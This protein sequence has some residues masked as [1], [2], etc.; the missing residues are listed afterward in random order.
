M[1]NIW[2]KI[3]AIIILSILGLFYIIPWQS[4]GL[5]NP[6]NLNSS[7]YKLGLDL[8][9][10]IELDYKINLEERKKEKWYDKNK[11]KN[12]I[13]QLKL[14]VDKRISSLWIDDSVIT[15]A[16]YSWEQ[17]II[18]QIPLKWKNLKEDKKNIER[19]KAAVWKVVKIMFKEPRTSKL[20]PQDWEER[21]NL[22]KQLLEKQKNSKYNFF[23]IADQYRD[24]YD[25]VYDWNKVLDKDIFNKIFKDVEL[26]K[27]LVPKIVETNSWAILTQINTNLIEDWYFV[28]NIED[29]K[30]DKVNFDYAYIAK[31]PSDWIPAKDSKWRVLDDKYFVKSWVSKNQA[32]LPQ[33]ELIFNTEWWKIFGEITK[34]AAKRAEPNNLIAIF[35][36]W[37]LLT[38]PSVHEA[39]YGGRA[40]ITWNY[41]PQEAEQL[42]NNINTW[43]IP[44]PIYLT[45]ERSID[46]KLGWN[47]LEK[48]IK[49]WVA[50]LILIFIF[51]IIVYRLSWVMA[52]IALVVYTILVL[53]VIKF[54][55]N[56]LT[57]AS[58]AWLIL[59]IWIA[60]DANVLIFE[61]IKDELRDHPNQ[62][63]I[64]SIQ[65]WFNNSWSAIWD[66]NITWLIIS[67]ILYIFWVNM[68]KWFGLM[69]GIWIVVSLLTAMWVSRIFTLALWKSKI[70]NSAFIGFNKKS[71]NK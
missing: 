16:N 50:W 43:V 71:K 63:R 53:V 5:T 44:A 67:I 2:L 42:A 52:S 37:E 3:S 6:L 28:L 59:S 54:F 15:T 22:A 47:A 25:R 7:N 36:W 58:I 65:V 9:W 27:W 17:H 19:V 66:S 12:I 41:T 4:L 20:T 51:L 30:N 24:S 11:E 60:I 32:W 48:L 46:P 18:V 40:V 33:V 34:Q 70:S 10:W 68:I 29:F 56:I 14:I 38:A 8:K 26:K 39:I 31:K 61:R 21:K 35:V 49:A 64:K 69:L 57:L 62:D 1:K 45:S 13:E 23:V 55:G